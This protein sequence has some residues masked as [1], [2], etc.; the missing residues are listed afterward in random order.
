[1]RP[2]KEQGRTPPEGGRLN[3]KSRPA[4]LGGSIVPDRRLPPQPKRTAVNLFAAMQLRTSERFDSAIGP[5]IYA[6]RVLQSR[7][8]AR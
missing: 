3:E 5:P 8:W 7:L 4:E 1:M 6:R 2:V